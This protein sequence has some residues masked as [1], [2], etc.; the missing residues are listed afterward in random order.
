M[1]YLLRDFIILNLQKSSKNKIV[2]GYILYSREVRKRIVQKN[3][4]SNF[5]E[6][7]R[8]VGNEWRSLT[9]TEKQNWEDRAAKLNEETK[10]L[11]ISEEC[12]SP[13]LPAD[14]VSLISFIH[15]LILRTNFLYPIVLVGCPF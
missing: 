4:D 15:F 1:L 3:P 6:I 9:S 10:A 14:F 8:I 5:G 13:G 2:T 11:L 7:S 12:A